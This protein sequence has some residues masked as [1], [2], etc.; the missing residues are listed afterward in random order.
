MTNGP[1]RCIDCGFLT[2]RHNDQFVELDES[3]RSDSRDLESESLCFVRA[4]QFSF[5]RETKSSDFGIAARFFT[6]DLAADR[7]CD[8]FRKWDQGFTPKEHAE[9]ALHDS[10]R[11]FH[12]QCIEDDRKWRES[13]AEREHRWRTEDKKSERL[14][15]W[16][17]ALWT[18][19]AAAAGWVLALATGH[20]GP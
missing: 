6:D 7:I 5:T 3:I 18:L 13:M 4:A 9:M 10:V 2:M 12:K 20:G 14:K 1:V 15:M 8:S 16:A 17:V 11:E 19:F